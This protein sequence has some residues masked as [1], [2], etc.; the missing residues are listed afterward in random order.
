MHY[1]D[2]RGGPEK[3]VDVF[4]LR[5]GESARDGL[6]RVFNETTDKSIASRCVLTPYAGPEKVPAGVRRYKFVPDKAYQREFDRKAIPGDI[7]EPACGD[8]GENYDAIE[9]WEVHAG[10]AR[11]LFVRY[12]QDTPLFDEQTLKILK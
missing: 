9:Y 7:P 6:R 4:D 1:S 12:G 3:V 10:A 5:P 8:R 2:D 11:I